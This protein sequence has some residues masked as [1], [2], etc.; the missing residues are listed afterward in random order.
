M[1]PRVYYTPYPNL[2]G[3]GAIKAQ[4]SFKEMFCGIVIIKICLKSV[5]IIYFIYIYKC[6]S[7]PSDQFLVYYMRAL[8]GGRQNPAKE[9]FKIYILTIF[10]KSE[11]IQ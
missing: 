4:R 9:F 2:G 11:R 7:P 1:Q 8:G 5:C 3:G 6:L 10:F